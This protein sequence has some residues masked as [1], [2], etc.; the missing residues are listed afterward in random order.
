M[1]SAYTNILK[2]LLVPDDILE[3]ILEID[4]DYLHEKGYRTLVL[5]IDNTI[6]P[7]SENLMTLNMLS[8]VA[9]VKNSGF[10]LY[11]LSNNSSWKRIERICKQAET[12]GFYFSCKPL[13]Y[14]ARDMAT[15]YGFDIKKSVIVG[16]QVLTDVIV[17]NWLGAFSILVDPLD[18]KLSFLKTLQRDIE[19]NILNKLSIN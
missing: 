19:L 4:L 9:R 12:K 11:F 7:R 2:K 15:R 14:S 16:D 13:V 3:S 5:D 17:A 1:I 10:E 18:K 8:W 6:V